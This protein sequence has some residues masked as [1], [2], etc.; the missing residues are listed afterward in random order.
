MKRNRVLLGLGMV[1]CLVVVGY[2]AAKAYP[3]APGVTPANFAR[4]RV[5]MPK[6]E[7]EAILGEP[8]EFEVRM[9]GH[10]WQRWEG[11]DCTVVLHLSEI[12][13]CEILD[14]DLVT[15]GRRVQVPPVSESYLDVLRRWLRL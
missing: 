1:A 14:G 15:S 11:K 4:L 12:L 3:P 13:P 2:L 9:T 7:V 6:T 10:Y 5:G 8:G